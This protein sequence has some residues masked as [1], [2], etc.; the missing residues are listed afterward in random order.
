MNKNLKVSICIPTY[1]RHDILKKNLDLFLKVNKNNFEIIIVDDG[2]TDNTKEL[3]YNVA[4]KANFKIKYFYQEN[5][6]TS[7]SLLRTILNSSGEYIVYQGSDDFVVI[8]IFEKFLNG[9]YDHILLSESIAGIAFKCKYNDNQIVGDN[10]ADEKISKYSIEHFY[11]DNRGDKKIY[12]KNIILNE[13]VK[14]Y[15]DFE[16]HIPSSVLL[17]D[18]DKNYSFYFSNIAIAI[19]NYLKDGITSNYFI[20]IRN[21]PQGYLVLSSKI[22]N[23]KYKNN[24]NSLILK[25]KQYIN[26]TKYLLFSLINLKKISHLEKLALYQYLL[27]FI[28]SP[29][30]LVLFLYDN[31]K[32]IQIILNK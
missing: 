2:S 32:K 21:F 16:S 19:K 11:K 3:V 29:F 6:G 24:L 5:Q 30:G 17:I 28:L 15:I 14:K 7:K 26:F 27:I 13:I 10:N 20:H 25:T 23:F 9:D 1:N 8:D 22:I 4:K 18:I 31:L 12:I